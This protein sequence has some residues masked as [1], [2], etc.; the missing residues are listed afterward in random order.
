MSIKLAPLTLLTALMSTSSLLPASD[1]SQEMSSSIGEYETFNPYDPNRYNNPKY[2]TIYSYDTDDYYLNSYRHDHENSKELADE[3]DESSEASCQCGCSCSEG[4]DCGCSETGVC[5]CSEYNRRHPYEN[6]PDYDPPPAYFQNTGRD[7][8]RAACCGRKGL[9]LPEDPVLFRPLIADPRE[10]TY[11]AGWRFDDQVL[12][13][14]VIDVSFGDSV[15]FYRWCKI[16]PWDGEMQI[17]LEGALW[18]VFDP[19]HESAPLIN[20]DYYGGLVLSYAI[21]E[22]AFR[23]RGYHISSHIGD[24]FLI[25]HPH[26]RRRNV[27]NEYIDFYVSCDWTDEIRLY[28]GI[29][30]IVGEDSEFHI[31]R[32][33]GAVG[34]E[35]RLHRLG[36]VDWCTHLY[37]EPFLGMHFRHNKSFKH[38]VDATY[39]LGYE[40]GKLCGLC[41][42]VRLY[43][44]YHDGYSLEG[45]FQ[46]DATNYFSIR[47]SYGF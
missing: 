19:L 33:F 44:E 40:W 31:G 3:S 12:A 38:H 13:R 39:V 8:R 5:N 11:S 24:E 37:G 46:K 26:F 20:A 23:L 4:C 15:P 14:N 18:A 36:F 30:Y 22:W 2:N 45:Q 21:G 6:N 47:M 1:S 42:K 32:F 41:R 35:I 9:W 7:C 27:S 34:T 10:V 43:M 28:S 29:G 17:D 25:D 16:W